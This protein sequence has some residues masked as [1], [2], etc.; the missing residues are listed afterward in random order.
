MPE[1]R[2][3][4]VRGRKVDG[5]LW[6]LRGSDRINT[7]NRDTGFPGRLPTTYLR[8]VAVFRSVIVNPVYNV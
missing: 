8:E 4:D 6:L 2:D 1:K 5:V 3:R 7:L